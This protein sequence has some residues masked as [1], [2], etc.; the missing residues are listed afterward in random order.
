MIMRDRTTIIHVYTIRRLLLPELVIIFHRLGA[1][2]LEVGV[3]HVSA[4]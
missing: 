3:I 2:M 4:V 1:A